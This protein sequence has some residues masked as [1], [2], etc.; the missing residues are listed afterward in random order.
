MKRVFAVLLTMALLFA[1]SV[2][3]ASFG[4][5]EGIACEEAVMV[6]Q[7]IGVIRGD[8]E[9]K[10]NPDSSLTR[11]ELA[12]FVL[13]LKGGMAGEGKEIF[14]DVPSSH[15]AFAE[16]TA[17]YQTGIVEGV[18]EGMFAPDATASY[19]QA[20]KMVVSALGYSVV[21]EAMGGYPS[22]YLTKAMQLELLEGISAEQD[23]AF[24]RGNMAILLYNALDIPLFEKTSYGTDFGRY[25]E[26][27]EKTALSYLGVKRI[28]DTVNANYYT[29]LTAT[30]K[31]V[32]SNEVI[33][34]DTLLGVGETNADALLG[35]SVT[36][37]AQIASKDEVPVILA[38]VQNKNS[39]AVCIDA[40]YILPETN[41][42]TFIYEKD[43]K[44][45]REQISGAKV[46]FNGSV[47]EN[48]TAADIRPESGTV[49]L[50]FNRG[51]DCDYILT[52]SIQN[53]IV[54]GKNVSEKTLFFT[55]GSEVVLDVDD[56]TS[57]TSFID[58]EGAPV[59]VEDC[60]SGD[61]ISVAKG[62]GVIRA[63]RSRK[64]A[65]GR[66]YE[67]GETEIRIEDTLYRL[68]KKVKESYLGVYADYL[69]DYTG[70]VVGVDQQNMIK[71]EYG[72]IIHVMDGKGL[73]GKAQFKMLTESGEVK[74]FET[75]EKVLLDTISVSADALLKSAKLMSGDKVIRQIV[76]Y[77]TNNEGEIS[78][79]E[80]ATD[81]IGKQDDESRYGVFSKDFYVDESIMVGSETIIYQGGTV[82]VFA[83]KYKPV[84]STKIFIVPETENDDK[85][86]RVYKQNQ[87][88]H[89]SE[90]GDD[91]QKNMYFYDINEGNIIGAILI[92]TADGGGVTSVPDY[93]DSM[94]VV[95]GI[96]TVMDGDEMKTKIKVLNSQKKEIELMPEE[97][98][99][100]Y[101]AVSHTDVT[102]DPCAANGVRKDK[103]AFSELCVGD[104]IQ[105]SLDAGTG[106][107]KRMNVIYR[108]KYPSQHEQSWRYYNS[109]ISL[110]TTEYM[111][112][113]SGVMTALGEVQYVTA[114]GAKTLTKNIAYNKEHERFYSFAGNIL[115]WDTEKECIINQDAT[116][117]DIHK[118]DTILSISSVQRQHYIIVY[119]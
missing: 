76:R 82:G 31:S 109:G 79:I 85:K 119:R 45:T 41:L 26:Q 72:V 92:L 49:T 105:F 108:V 57:R 42:H 71:D 104:V 100:L 21:A 28:R 115:I 111:N 4:D 103:I 60:R 59:T 15:W 118:G 53:F 97:D 6:L 83:G 80:T 95:T 69:L 20:V 43:G 24:S 110:H 9:N 54:S 34:G 11:A 74:V 99:N 77:R 10:F 114:Y 55:D 75:A 84:D 73:S 66:V 116:H 106:R 52:E 70:K 58:T 36:A 27:E 93:L 50:L 29:N 61:V 1:T 65:M 3:S 12:A 63:I 56:S 112:Y 39:R 25:A 47:K 19:A 102:K 33:I 38:L 64:T 101:F 90:G 2:V 14:S 17:A 91:F 51:S 89:S 88:L 86:C 44:E 98:T 23:A 113:G 13:R 46:I 8:K 62:E 107:I 81:Y 78:K 7:G 48:P 94:G 117:E 35:L 5:I 40:E 68:D 87:L 22:G 96:S 16:V 67:Q 18:G 37:Y 32:K 30:E